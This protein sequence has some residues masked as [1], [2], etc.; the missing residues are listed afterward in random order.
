MY[1]VLVNAF[2]QTPIESSE[3]LTDEIAKKS[4]ASTMSGPDSKQML[5]LA[6]T[7]I[8][9]KEILKEGSQKFPDIVGMN[10]R[11]WYLDA[12]KIASH[13]S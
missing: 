12:N 9:T 1:Q 7:T 2:N 13:L 10:P 4:W 8:L 3:L 11:C 6:K 5:T